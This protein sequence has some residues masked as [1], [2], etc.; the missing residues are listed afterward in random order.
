MNLLAPLFLAGLAALAVPI[1]LHLMH[2]EVPRRVIFPTI[3]HILKGQQFQSGRRGL[4]DFWTLL[5]RLAIL[6]LIV[7]LFTRPI[8]ENP[9]TAGSGTGKEIVL[10]YDLSASMSAVDFESFAVKKTQ[11][12]IEAE[13]NASFAMLASS[14]HIIDRAD[15][16][17][18]T[19]E[20]LAKVRVLRP[21]VVP[22]N[23]SSALSA[24]DRLFSETPNV[25]RLIYLFTDLQQQDW[26]PSSLPKVSARS[27]LE[28]VNPH[29]KAPPNVAIL[30]VYPE[31]FMRAQ[32]RRVR[33]TVQVRNYSLQP[34]QAKL[35]ITAG[36]TTSI[37]VRLRGEY[38]EKHV[39]D[40]EDPATNEAVVEIASL[41]GYQLDNAWHIWIGPRPPTQVA[42]I[43]DEEPTRQKQIEALFLRSALTVNTPGLPSTEVDVSGP[44]LLWSEDLNMYKAVFLLDAVQELGEVEMEA[45]QTY[46]KNGGTVVYVAGRRSADNLAKLNHWGITENHF[47]GILGQSDQ[48]SAYS[49][50]YMERGSSVTRV[51]EEESSDLLLF[52]I[53]KVAKLKTAE[54]A[55]I[56]LGINEA[57]PLLIQEDVGRGVCFTLAIN[58]SHLWSEFATSY[59]FLPLLDQIVQY[60]PGDEKK[61]GVLVADVGQDYTATAAAASLEV[62]EILAEPGIHMIDGTPLELNYT[63]LESDP[64]AIDS[65]EVYAQLLETGSPGLTVASNRPSSNLTDLRYAVA[66]ALGAFLF[67]ELL[68]AN[69]RRSRKTAPVEE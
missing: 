42:V 23:H 40:L 59:S 52:P 1:I 61:R 8:W 30:N 22:G 53:Y 67:I 13:P 38:S 10:F 15:L 34:M 16:G 50:G 32:K 49:L 62:T 45:L 51:F 44:E 29:E 41:E 58:L 12:I 60:Q 19:S 37:D 36:T 64:R 14:D 26:A 25:Q 18:P 5:A 27:E 69:F 56:L 48:L 57:T 47:L 35:S 54:N 46:L 31:H 7:L 21:G 20:V 63:R 66:I 24:I 43:F 6:A 28:I 2:R 65:L 4:R 33:A 55:T 9:K 11:K 17:T 3:R 39:I 68:F